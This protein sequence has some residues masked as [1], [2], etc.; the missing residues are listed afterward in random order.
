[1]TLD[2]VGSAAG[3]VVED[4][5]VSKDKGIV[6]RVGVDGGSDEESIRMDVVEY[7]A[8][9]SVS[10]GVDAAPVEVLEVFIKVD[11]RVSAASDAVIVD[12]FFGVFELDVAEL[13]GFASTVD[14]A[15]GWPAASEAESTFGHMAAVPRETKKNPIKVPSWTWV[16]LQAAIID[17]VRLSSDSIHSVEH[18]R[19]WSKSAVEQADKGVL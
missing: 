2:V 9:F 7:E 15:R 13:L 18:A 19:P 17:N 12:D 11:E 8:E 14:V 4:A 1:M 3:I 16:P 10:S 5:A 6:D